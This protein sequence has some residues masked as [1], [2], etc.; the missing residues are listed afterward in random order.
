MVSQNNKS[1]KLI[2]KF[3][4]NKTILNTF[5]N[6]SKNHIQPLALLNLISSYLFGLSKL[7]KNIPTVHTTFKIFKFL[8]YIKNKTSFTLHPDTMPR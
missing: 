7:H 4:N 2:V 5:Q 1:G 6:T 8:V 3:W